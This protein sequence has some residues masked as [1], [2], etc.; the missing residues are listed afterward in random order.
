MRATYLDYTRSGYARRWANA[1]AGAALAVAER[2]AWLAGAVGQAG[3]LL[4]IGCGGGDL[5]SMLDA[6]GLRPARYI[7]LDLLEERV[8]AARRAV[9]WGEFLTG[10]A[11]DVPLPDGS[12]DVVVAATLFSSLRE[13]FLREAVAGEIARVLRPGGRLVV[14][15][16]RY[17]SPRN[18]AVTPVTVTGLRALFPGWPLIARS[19]TVLPPIARSMLAAGRRRYRALASIPPMRSHIAAILHRP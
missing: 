1:G 17:P 16:I 3:S 6:R 19:M 11:D 14:Y 2:D 10:S 5:A 13:R 8:D 12:V 18:R 7:G 9:P 15:D 4:D